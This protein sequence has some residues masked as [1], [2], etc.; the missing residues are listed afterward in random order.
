MFSKS[1]FKQHIA[2]KDTITKGER[3]KFLY[4]H[5]TYDFALPQEWV[6]EM[7]KK[8]Y[9]YDT[10]VSSFVWGYSG[11]SDNFGQAFPLNL[12]ACEMLE[13]CDES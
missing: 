12:N 7:V 5:F 11:E 10:V 4:P 1:T 3:A 9:N 8:G 13:N 2:M 6:N